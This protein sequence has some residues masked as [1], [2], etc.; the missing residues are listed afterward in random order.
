MEITTEASEKDSEAE[1]RLAI[2][3]R[4]EIRTIIGF[5]KKI[6]GFVVD[7]NEEKWLSLESEYLDFIDPYME[8]GGF[9]NGL[10]EF[11]QQ[12]LR[13]RIQTYKTTLCLYNSRH[14][15]AVEEPIKEIQDRLGGKECRNTE[16]PDPPPVPP[17]DITDG[18]NVDIA[19]DGTDIHIIPG[20]IQKLLFAGKLKPGPRE[21]R[22]L[23]LCGNDKK[24]IRW[25]VEN[26][27]DG[28]LT[29]DNY[30]EYIHCMRTEETIKRY[31]RSARKL[32]RIAMGIPTPSPD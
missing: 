32:K 26:N 8:K 22:Y 3:L 1:D 28:E 4:F 13:Q 7:F 9:I 18:A 23:Q 19:P 12:Y 27:Y 14:N 2:I 16:N 25:I 29:P 21:G 24:F 30:F 17:I 5:C 10:N 6:D 15:E 11:E 20:I 31:F